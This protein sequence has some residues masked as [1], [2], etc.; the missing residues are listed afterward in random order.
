MK[1]HIT[2]NVMGKRAEN[3]GPKQ[4]PKKKPRHQVRVLAVDAKRTG[5]KSLLLLSRSGPV[6]LGASIFAD[7]DLARPPKTKI[8]LA[9][10][11]QPVAPNP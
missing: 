9:T 8:V 10:V 2:V 7:S 4:F 3:T 5:N 1:F 11:A 6:M